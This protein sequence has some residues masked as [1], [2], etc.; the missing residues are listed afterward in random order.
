VI[1]LI[2]TVFPGLYANVKAEIIEVYP[3]SGRGLSYG[4]GVTGKVWKRV[5]TKP[6]NEGW[7]PIY[8]PEA[9]LEGGDLTGIWAPSAEIFAQA[10][11]PIYGPSARTMRG[12]K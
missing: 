2:A 10:R 8:A 4:K 5:T 9:Q 11:A 7:R 6:L 1:A 3:D 12:E